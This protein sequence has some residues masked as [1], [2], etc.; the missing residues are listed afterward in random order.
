MSESVRIVVII[1]SQV[2]QELRLGKALDNLL[3]AKLKIVPDGSFEKLLLPVHGQPA[4][5]GIT[6]SEIP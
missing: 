5:F 1:G 2:Q 3:F 6:L 4:V